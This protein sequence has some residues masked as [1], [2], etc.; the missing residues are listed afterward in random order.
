MSTSFIVDSSDAGSLLRGVMLCFTIYVAF[1]DLPLNSW[2]TP[3][4]HLKN[5]HAVPRHLICAGEVHVNLT[6]IS[7]AHH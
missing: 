3:L 6:E 4:L 5:P 1:P 7:A 2:E